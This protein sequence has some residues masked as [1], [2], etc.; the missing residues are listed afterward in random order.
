[1]QFSS[2]LSIILRI[3]QKFREIQFLKSNLLLNYLYYKSFEKAIS[4]K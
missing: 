2:E 4:Q 3:S 1:M